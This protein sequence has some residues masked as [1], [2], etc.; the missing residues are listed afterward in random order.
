M[1]GQFAGREAG[2]RIADVDFLDLQPVEEAAQRIG[3]VQRRAGVADSAGHVFGEFG[4]QP[5]KLEA[6]LQRVDGGGKV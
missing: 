1:G 2:Q 4:H 6:A 5:H 3:Q